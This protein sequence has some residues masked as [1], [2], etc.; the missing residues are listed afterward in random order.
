M[1][2]KDTPARLESCYYNA[3]KNAPKHNDL[4]TSIDKL[5]DAD[6]IF[7]QEV[8][9][10]DPSNFNK[11]PIIDAATLLQQ[12]Y[13]LST[14]GS[15]GGLT[16]RLPEHI[17]IIIKLLPGNSNC[18]DCGCSD[19]G[20]ANNSRQELTWASAAH[21]TVLCEECA[22]LHM[23]MGRDDEILSFETSL[24]WRFSEIISM[25]EGGNEAFLSAMYL[26]GE[27]K[28]DTSNAK[29]S[30]ALSLDEFDDIYSSSLSMSR[31]YR[32]M[33]RGKVLKL[34]NGF[35]RKRAS[36]SGQSRKLTSTCILDNLRNR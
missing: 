26:N 20:T 30:T 1:P 22:L 29:N 16:M 27:R 4:F 21:G 14:N 34:S 6:T 32:K 23:R 24:D 5:S 36:L 13:E 18:C 19:G 11:S 2:L 8:E 12:H 35:T 28:R 31:Y 17:W 10:G 15:V 33:L 25:L 7:S 9:Y 3:P